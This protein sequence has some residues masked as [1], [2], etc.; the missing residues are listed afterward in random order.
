MKR[1]VDVVDHLMHK[2]HEYDERRKQRAKERENKESY[3]FQPKINKKSR[4]M[5]NARRKSTYKRLYNNSVTK[6]EKIEKQRQQ[7][8]ADEI[9]EVQQGPKINKHS[10]KLVKQLGRRTNATIVSSLKQW[11]ERKQQKLNRLRAEQQRAKEEAYVG[12][13]KINDVSKWL[14]NAR[15]NRAAMRV[16]DRLLQYKEQ[17]EHEHEAKRAMM[18]AKRIEQATPRFATNDALYERLYNT[19]AELT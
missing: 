13:P 14:V 16:E 5:M 12:K 10:K 18:D 7:Q 1:Q 8:Q 3:T 11:D 15:Q 6:N 9:A 17:K 4:A 2:Q 19:A